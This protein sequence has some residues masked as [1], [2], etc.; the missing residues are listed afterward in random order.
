MPLPGGGARWR[1]EPGTHRRPY[2]WPDVVFLGTCD[3]RLSASLTAHA[4]LVYEG[5][6]GDDAAAHRGW[7][8]GHFMPEGDARQSPA[9][10]IKWGVH[11]RGDK[12]EQWVAEE[13]PTAAIIL[14]GGRLRVELPGRSVLLDRQ[15]SYVVFRGVGHS[16]IAEEDST[17]VCVR[18]PSAPGY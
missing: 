8:L 14:A 4:G 1:Q 10:E 11:A 16:W 12:R 9:V 5:F 13:Q 15:G 2:T 6:A 3:P 7:L 17:I 18:W